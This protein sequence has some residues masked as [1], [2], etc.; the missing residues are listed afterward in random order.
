VLG[1]TLGN[2]GEFA[3]L[4]AWCGQ[5]RVRPV[6]DARY[7]LEAVHAAFDHLASGTQFGKIA[8]EIG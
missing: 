3:D 8:I 2:P 6:I 7:P 1:S 4:L 5:G